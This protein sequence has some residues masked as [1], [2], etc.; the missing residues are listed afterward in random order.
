MG[1]GVQAK[2][3]IAKREGVG[4]L[5]PP[6]ALKVG[7]L[8]DKARLFALRNKQS[9]YREELKQLE[10]RANLIQPKSELWE[11]QAFSIDRDSLRT[12]KKPS[13]TLRAHHSDLEHLRFLAQKGRVKQNRNEI[14]HH[15]DLEHLQ[16]VVNLRRKLGFL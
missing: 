10:D 7:P 14:E 3:F 1:E 2:V 16:R 13:E 15:S 4:E 11:K 6:I 9:E 8:T 12:S 5:S